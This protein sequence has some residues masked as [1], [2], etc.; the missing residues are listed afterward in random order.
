MLKP[1][2]I[3]ILLISNHKVVKTINF[4]NKKYIGDPLNTIK[5]FNDKEVDEI[6]VLDIEASKYKRDPDYSFIERILS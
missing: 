1:R 4:Q 5:I 3:P 6:I 2:I